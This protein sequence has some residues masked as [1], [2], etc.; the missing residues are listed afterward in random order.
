MKQRHAIAEP[1]SPGNRK[2]KG[3]RKKRAASAASAGSADAALE[4]AGLHSP[5]SLSI[6]ADVASVVDFLS[7]H[8]AVT[9]VNLHDRVGVIPAE[10][11]DWERRHWPLRLP[12]DLKAFLTIS[13]GLQLEWFVNRI[14]IV[15]GEVVDDGASSRPGSRAGSPAVGAQQGATAANAGGGKGGSAD[16]SKAAASKQLTVSTTGAADTVAGDR[17]NEVPLG[18]MLLNR[19]E[20]IKPC[21]D[22]TPDDLLSLKAWAMQLSSHVALGAGGPSLDVGAQNAAAA[23]AAAAAAAVASSPVARRGEDGDGAE[24]PDVELSAAEVEQLRVSA[25][26]RKIQVDAF[27]L[28]AAGSAGCPVY[29]VYV[30]DP[31]VEAA[32]HAVLRATAEAGRRSPTGGLAVNARD[33]LVPPPH[34]YVRDLAC[35]WHY[36]ASSFTHYFRLLTRHLGL[37]GWQLAFTPMGLDPTNRFLLNLFSPERVQIDLVQERMRR[38]YEQGGESG[39]ALLAARYK[40]TSARR[41]QRRRRQH[42][43][44]QKSKKASEK[45]DKEKKKGKGGATKLRRP[46]SAVSSI[47]KGQG[48]RRAHRRPYTA[49]RT[50]TRSTSKGSAPDDSSDSDAVG[51]GSA[52]G[53]ST[54]AEKL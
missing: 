41:K 38:A 21:A 15:H 12:D 46:G 16:A 11:N 5:S 54:R 37:P 36:I 53:A 35:R 40:Q 34:V 29:L 39:A 26:L 19:L 2:R 6:F 14:P 13:N 28:D 47:W 24:A 30:R 1:P 22:M 42:E 33:A 52:D 20:D 32:R 44:Q 4:S 48:K 45:K 3:S 23:R 7:E 10:I 18:L 49:S 31:A 17:S 9:R 50:R 51:G 25:R 27:E 43:R 8:Y